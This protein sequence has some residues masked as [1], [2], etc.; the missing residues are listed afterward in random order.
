MNVFELVAMIK[1]NKDSYTQ[2]LNEASQETKTAGNKIKSAIGTAGKVAGTAFAALGTAAVGAVSGVT[3]FASSSA[4]AMD[5]I[6][7]QSQKMGMS[8]EAYQEWSHAMSLSGMDISTLKAG[9]KSMQ[10]AMSGVSEDGE[11]T[12]S[13]FAELGISV[14]D[15]NGELRDVEEVMNET[16]MKLADMEEGA[17]RATYANKLFGRSGVEMAPLL[18]SGSEAIVAMKQE[19]HDLGLV[20]EEDAVKQGAVL[21]DTLSNLKDGFGALKTSLGN[22][23][24]PVVQR[25]AE[26]L[27]DFLPRIEKIFDRIGPVLI[28]MLDKIMPPLFDL[29]DAILPIFETAIDAILPLVAELAETVL[30]VISDVLSKIAP[31]LSELF[32]RLMPIVTRILEALMPILDALW[33]VISTILDLVMDL[34]S[35]ILDL[36]DVLLKPLNALL[37]PIAKLLEPIA[38]LLELIGAVLKPILELINAILTPLIEFVSG[39]FGGIIEGLTGISDGLSGDDGVAGGLSTVANYITGPFGKAFDILG[40]ILGAAMEVIGSVFSGIVEFIKDPKQ[41][42]SDFFGWIEERVQAAK[43]LLNSLKDLQEANE[44]SEKA[45]SSLQ[46]KQQEILDAGGQAADDLRRRQVEV[47]AKGWTLSTTRVPGLANGGVIDPN[48]PFLALLGDQKSGKNIEAPLE[49]IKQAMVEA[50]T[51]D[52]PAVSYRNSTSPL[53]AQPV[54]V[55]IRLEGEMERLFRAMQ[56]QDALNTA[57]TGRPSWSM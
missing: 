36:V 43:S 44:A 25:F 38:P 17:D 9:M 18:N 45:R 51:N 8:T 28:D 2:G 48:K 15:T 27:L 46:Q 21:N 11:D 57:S 24:M 31:I 19:A 13:T 4:E 16:I 41:A 47:G 3:K 37:A 42:L 40:D 49:T 20:F 33:P 52:L 55:N 10:T 35:P 14:R 6:D 53:C 29:V 54:V 32:E 34:L 5:V 39:I 26:K 7:K 1:L 12:T 22:S 30:P 50:L 23:L 56:E